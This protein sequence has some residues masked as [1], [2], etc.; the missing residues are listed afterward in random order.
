MQIPSFGM[1][2]QNSREFSCVQKIAPR[3]RF[4]VEE[5]NTWKRVAWVLVWGLARKVIEEA[6]TDANATIERRLCW[7][8]LAQRL[9][10]YRVALIPNAEKTIP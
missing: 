7:G 3:L 1:S 4:H 6:R 8:R 9:H 10:L 2:P 5:A